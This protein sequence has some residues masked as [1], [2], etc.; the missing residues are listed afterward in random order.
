MD[1]FAV[2]FLMLLVG[3]VLGVAIGYLYAIAYEVS[4]EPEFIVDMEMDDDEDE[5]DYEM[6]DIPDDAPESL[7]NVLQKDPDALFEVRE[8]TRWGKIWDVITSDGDKL[9]IYPESHPW[10]VA[11]RTL[12][13]ADYVLSEFPNE[14]QNQVAGA[15]LDAE[16]DGAEAQE[17]AVLETMQYLMQKYTI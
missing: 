3:L 16:P 17:Q 11:N 1:W 5:E 14:M 6:P 4:R 12:A 8:E 15:A 9:T 10:A 2:P 13:K 7:I